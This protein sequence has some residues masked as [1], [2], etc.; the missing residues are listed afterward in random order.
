MKSIKIN[1]PRN[2]LKNETDFG[3]NNLSEKN[4][5]NE[6]EYKLIHEYRNSFKYAYKQMDKLLSRGKDETSKTRWSGSTA[7]TCIIENVPE[8]KTRWIHIAN[9]GDVEAIVITFDKNYKKYH[10][11]ISKTRKYKILTRLHTLNDCVQDR[12]NLVRKGIINDSR[13]YI[14]PY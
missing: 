1:S 5:L 3:L 9:C 4:N 6:F 10:K 2:D 13:L 7:V 8:T 11:N 12:E 14:F